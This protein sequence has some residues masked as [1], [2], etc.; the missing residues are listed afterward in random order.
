MSGSRRGR[1][2]ESREQCGA[3]TDWLQ[4]LHLSSGEKTE[5]CFH[6]IFVGHRAQE[7]APASQPEGETRTGERSVTLLG[8]SVDP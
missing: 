7:G 3:I 1:R 5:G 8:S 4:D 6:K 2:R